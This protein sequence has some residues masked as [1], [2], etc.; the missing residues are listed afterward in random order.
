MGGA[1]RSAYEKLGS[2]EVRRVNRREKR[3][4]TEVVRLVHLTSLVAYDVQD[5]LTKYRSEKDSWEPCARVR[6]RM[7][8]RG[9]CALR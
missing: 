2:F 9:A 1:Q 7:H 4:L 3:C 8:E 6:K 5:S